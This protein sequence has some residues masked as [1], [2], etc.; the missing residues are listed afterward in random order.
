LI[1]ANN[2]TSALGWCLSSWLILRYVV[3]IASIS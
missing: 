3:G 1:F 2:S